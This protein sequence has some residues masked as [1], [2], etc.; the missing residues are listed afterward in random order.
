MDVFCYTTAHMNGPLTLFHPLI[1][2]FIVVRPKRRSSTRSVRRQK[3][4]QTHKE[5]ARRLIL[6]RLE[7]LN[8]HYGL[9]YG[10]VAIRDQRSRWGSCSKKGNLNFNYRLLFLPLPLVDLV[11]AHELCHLKEFNH[12]TAFWGLVAE[13]IP[14]LSLR[15]EE[16]RRVRLNEHG[17]IHNAALAL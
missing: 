15:R 14:D 7:S 1:S 8:K 2:R 11:I 5:A 12:S 4:Y 3:D 13:T 17:G 9:S 10:R 6:E 16:L